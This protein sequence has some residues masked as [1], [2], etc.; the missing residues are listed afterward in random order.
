MAGVNKSPPL[1]AMWRYFGGMANF[2]GRQRGKLSTSMKA[3][4]KSFLW[5]EIF[6][7]TYV[8]IWSY[9]FHIEEWFIFYSRWEFKLLFLGEKIAQKARFVT[10]KGPKT[11]RKGGIFCFQRPHELNFRKNHYHF[12]KNVYFL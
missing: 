2:I 8:S 7:V 12:R 4:L 10:S 3:G 1:R 5:I 11:H 9:I 6:L